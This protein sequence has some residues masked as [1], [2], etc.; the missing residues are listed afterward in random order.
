MKIDASDHARAPGLSG[1]RGSSSLRK[2]DTSES[3]RLSICLVY[4]LVVLAT[5]QWT[6]AMSTI[7]IGRHA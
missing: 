4:S 3:R 5:P 1:R 6:F 2:R 7:E